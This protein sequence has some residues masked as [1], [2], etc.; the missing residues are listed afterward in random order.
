VE[1]GCAAAADGRLIAFW[2]GHQMISLR[3]FCDFPSRLLGAAVCVWLCAAAASMAALPALAQDQT[4]PP[5]TAPEAQPQSPPQAEKKDTRTELT[6]SGPTSEA[7]S[8]VT[9]TAVVTGAGGVPT[10]SVTFKDGDSVLHSA[11]LSQGRAQWTT[12]ALAAGQHAVTAAY[13]GDAAFRASVSEARPHLVQQRGRAVLVLFAAIMLAALMVLLRR[14]LFRRLLRPTA[15]MLA[16][17]FRHLRRL[18]RLGGRASARQRP[19]KSAVSLGMGALTEGFTETED[20]IAADFDPSSVRIERNSRFVCAWIR[21]HPEKHKHDP[22]EDFKKAEQLFDAEVPLGSNPLNL[23]DDI[24]NAFIVN[25]FSGSD[26]PCFHILSEFRKTISANVLALIVT[27]TLIVS[28]VLVVN[29]TVPT[30]IEFYQR[31]GLGEALPPTYSV[32]V[33][34]VELDTAIELNKL[35]F[36]LMSC[37]A[38]FLLMW[39]FNNLT[40]EQSQRYNG[41]MMHTFLVDYLSNIRNDFEALL[42]RATQAVIRETGV[43]AVTRESLVLITNLNWMPIRMQ[44]IK[45]FLRNILFQI[46][47]NRAFAL[48]IVPLL[49]GLLLFFAF[50]LLALFELFVLGS[51]GHN[52]WFYP[53]FLWLLY[54]YGRYLARALAPMMESVKEDEYVRYHLGLVDAMT[55]IMGSY[56]AQLDQFRTRFRPGQGPG[57]Q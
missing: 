40:Y 45:Q 13:G 30:S 25:L 27:Y 39:A 32:P 6:A 20:A 57:G 48:F 44:F 55:Q 8:A 4:A 14:I 31:L 38:G 11:E 21:P 42:A 2:M 18:L 7:G 24:H 34:G 17:L 29:L 50:W 15:R 47:R 36:A 37:L 28:A 46:H 1:L 19:G 16:A 51:N 54:E 56:A 23:Y 52:Y 41:Q 12:S 53:L 9:F 43:E 3:S 26:K 22:E 10:G 5:T 35:M 49:F 33:L